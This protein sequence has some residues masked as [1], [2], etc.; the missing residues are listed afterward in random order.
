MFETVHQRKNTTK[1]DVEVHLQFIELDRNPLFIAI[2]V[3]ITE[4]K[5][6][7]KALL[8][9]ENRFRSIFQESASIMYLI[10]PDNGQFMPVCNFMV[11]VKRSY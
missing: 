8:E 10:N 1:Y 2:I 9:N 7:E 4:R 11:G 5:K 3:D 6:A